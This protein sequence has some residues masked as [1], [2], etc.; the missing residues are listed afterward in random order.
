MEG[1]VPPGSTRALVQVAHGPAVGIV[2]GQPDQPVA[3]AFFRAYPGSGLVIQRLARRQ[4]TP[5]RA[6]EVARM[7]SPLTRFSVNPSS[8][9]ACAA[10]SKAHELVCLPKFLGLWWSISFSRFLACSES[11]AA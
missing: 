2:V 7:V 4:F 5:V 10:N 8:K 11:K 3:P 6:K 1:T 9:L